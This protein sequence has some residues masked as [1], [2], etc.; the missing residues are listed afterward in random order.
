VSAKITGVVSG[1]SEVRTAFRMLDTGL[2]AR[3]RGAVAESTHAIEGGA[4]ARVAVSGPNSR[5]AKG[6]PGPGE[7]RDSI[8][9][10]FSESGFVGYVK[11]GYG[12]LR[13][14]SKAKAPTSAGQAR[15]QGKL[16]AKAKR[17]AGSTKGLGMHAMV[18]EYGAPREGKEAQPYIRPA[19]QA[20]IEPHAA[21]CQQAINGAVDAAGGA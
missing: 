17:R 15:R 13:R 12:K 7:L 16:R 20:E 21:R 3:L 11:A 14:S 10:E 4:K 19:R 8:R 6:R 5:K 9:S 1:I 18:I 2:Q